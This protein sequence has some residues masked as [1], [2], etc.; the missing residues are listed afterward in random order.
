MDPALE[1][2]GDESPPGPS[3]QSL[4]VA[5]FHIAGNQ[6]ENF[7]FFTSWRISL[8]KACVRGARSS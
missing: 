1:G 5:R 3:P 6:G 4:Y 7:V 8:A 2:R